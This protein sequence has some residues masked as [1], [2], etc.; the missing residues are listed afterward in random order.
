MNHKLELKEKYE[1]N[2]LRKFKARNTFRTSVILPDRYVSDSPVRKEKRNKTIIEKYQEENS[3]L[4]SD[5]IFNMKSIDKFIGNKSVLDKEIIKIIDIIG[6]YEKREKN[7]RESCEKLK[8]TQMNRLFKEFVL[9]DY[10]KR[11]CT[12]KNVVISALIGED[13]TKGELIRQA[14]EEKVKFFLLIYLDLD[15]LR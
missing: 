5:T 13:M 6:D 11:F 14:R 2:I 9:N 10:E 15:F 3:I 8:S 12:T 4:D 7:L 1:E